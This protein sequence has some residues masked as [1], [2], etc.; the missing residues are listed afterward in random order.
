MG[1]QF[2][3]SREFI[4]KLQ[5]IPKPKIPLF[6]VP[7][8]EREGVYK[9][10]RW[11]STA[12][13]ETIINDFVTDYLPFLYQSKNLI[14]MARK[15]KNVISLTKKIIEGKTTKTDKAK[16]IHNWVYS[17][18]TYK[19]TARIVPPWEIINIKTG[20][21]KSY[22]CLTGAMLGIAGIDCWLKLAKIDNID[23]LH[24]WD[25]AY[26]SWEPVDSV[27]AFVFR[28]VHP[29]AGYILFEV[30]KTLGYPP[31]PAPEAGTTIIPEKIKEGIKKYFAYGAIATMAGLG[32]WALM[33]R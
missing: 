3:P 7:Y 9:G 5:R 16:A 32:I 6:A 14:I 17:N 28:E 22:A 24:I 26:L 18:I 1:Y 30:D 13:D 31:K 29:V 33:E 15:D 19:R 11:Y 8:P 27:G 10:S 2:S 20:D 23:V 4:E 12:L 21:C 25:I